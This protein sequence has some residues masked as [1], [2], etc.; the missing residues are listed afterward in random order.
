M[1]ANN[2]NSPRQKM[3]NLMYLVFIAMMALN[4]SSEV[5]D[6]FELV[7]NSLSAS[8][9]NSSKRNEQVKS[10]LDKAYQANPTK[11]GEW[12]EKGV[13]V[14]VQ[15]DELYNY[16]DELKLRIVQ[17]SDGE[18][19]DVGNIEH[20][21]DL[22][23]ASR[24]ML[25]P[26]V[27][28]G[29]KLK[30][31]LEGY[32][33]NMCDI[34]SDPAKIEMFEATINTET[35]KKAGIIAGSWEAALFENMPVAAAITL[36]TKIQNDIRYIEGEALSTLITN[37]DV[38]DYRV[39]RIQALVIPKSQ[40]VTSGMPYEAQIVLAAVDSTKQPDYYLG[41]TLLKN[42]YISMSTSGVGERSISGKVVADGETYP[43]DA[44]YS[45]TESTATI[46]PTLM[47][48][49]YESIDNDLEIAMPGVPSGAVSASLTGSGSIKLKEKNI[50]TVTG[51]NMSSSPN[52][53]VTLN[54]TVGG[55]VVSASQDFKV[56]PLPEPLPFITYK[57]TDGNSR[58]FTHGQIAK[59]SLVDAPGVQAAIDDGVLNVPHTVTGFT[60]T[61]IDAMGNSIPEVS[62]SNEFTPRQKEFIR[63]LA[64]GKRFYIG[65]VKALDP[66]GKPLTIRYSMEII[67]N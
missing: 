52:V 18:K 19:G 1:A 30:E 4:V 63:N 48:F 37:V 60:M 40:I 64:R 43:F 66:M 38:G 16:I 31:R 29:K 5:L 46:A 17:V 11:V 41:E 10:N 39:N 27:G 61:V 15:S 33:T 58:K 55:R 44:K 47:K 42:D 28:E 3:I 62:N 32:R 54:A 8:S 14:K 53:K 24:V 36:L 49:L 7:E 22:E 25:A 67:V 45:V 34:V 50:W 56:R 26:V 13:K 23:A 51:L 35:P 65:N 9:A 59:R 2:P 21:D 12:Y 57:D 20:K 6:G